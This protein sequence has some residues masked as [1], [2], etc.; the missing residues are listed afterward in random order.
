M[1]REGRPGGRVSVKT[2]DAMNFE[3]IKSEQ[4]TLDNFDDGVEEGG[5]KFKLLVGQFWNFFF[6]VKHD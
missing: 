1:E 3:E 5:W 6:N 2:W 4:E